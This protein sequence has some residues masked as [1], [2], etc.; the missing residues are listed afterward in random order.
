ML[1]V[2]RERIVSERVFIFNPARETFKY[3]PNG[4]VA[5]ESG[6]WSFIEGSWI[7]RRLSWSERWSL[8]KV[9]LKSHYSRT[10]SRVKVTSHLLVVFEECSYKDRSLSGE[11]LHVRINSG[12]GINNQS[13]GYISK[14]FG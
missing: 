9:W 14:R 12:H 11:A 13:G 8:V 1:T 3:E 7:Q 10:W 5:T 6:V 4:F 2:D